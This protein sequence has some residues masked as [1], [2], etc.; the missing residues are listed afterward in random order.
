[1]TGASPE[2]AEIT[3]LDRLALLFQE[4]LTAIVR[5][6]ANRE[7]VPD[8]NGFRSQV[9]DALRAARKEARRRGY[10]EEQARL[11]AFAVVAFLDESVRS[12]TN[13]VLAG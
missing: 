7:Q 9:L 13:P 4:L 5:I 6:Y 3:A 2:A 1:M 11:A 12:S 8:L 10:S